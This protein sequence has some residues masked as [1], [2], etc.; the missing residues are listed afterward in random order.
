[1]PVGRAQPHLR[2]QMNPE[3]KATNNSPPSFLLGMDQHGANSSQSDSDPSRPDLHGPPASGV[4][5]HQPADLPRDG[6]QSAPGC[7]GMAGQS[8]P[9][10]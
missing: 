10:L 5:V 9:G 1:M 8:G 3:G 2:V 7:E 4:P 6:H